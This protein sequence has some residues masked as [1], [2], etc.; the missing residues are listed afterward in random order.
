[1]KKRKKQ[2]AAQKSLLSVQTSRKKSQPF[3]QLN[4]YTPLKIGQIDLYDSLREAIPVI[5]A[6]LDKIIRLIGDFEVTARTTGAKRI[7]K[8]F[9]NNVRVGASG[10]GL[11]VFVRQYLDRLLTWGTVVG[12]I[13]PYK[14]GGVAALYCANLRDIEIKEG[15]SPLSVKVCTRK[16]AELVPVPHQDRILI[17]ALNPMPGEVVGTSILR[18]LPFVSSVLLKIFNTIGTNWERVG[19]LRYAVTYKPSGSVPEMSLD[20]DTVNQISEEWSRAMS[21]SEGVRDFVAVGDVSVKVIGADGQILDAQVP[22]RQMLEQIIAKLGIPPFMLGLCWSST[23]RM[24]QQQ[25]DI[26][27]S[28]LESYRALLSPVI[29]RICEAHLRSLG[30]ADDVEVNWTDISLQDEVE[31]SRAALLRAQAE[32]TA[33]ANSATVSSKS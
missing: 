7:L 22:V 32:A 33:E 19:D 31:Q 1:M 6:A 12:E 3:M 21:S 8:N 17:S 23:E 5:D 10:Y 28:E 25:A 15:D 27:T 20:D 16:G 29:R 18:G 2:E 24:S 11:D 14:E 4:D 9:Q 13:V 26:L 30:I